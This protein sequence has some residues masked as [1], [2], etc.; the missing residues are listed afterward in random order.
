M[1]SVPRFIRPA[2]LMVD[3]VLSRASKGVSPLGRRSRNS[4]TVMTI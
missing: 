2:V 3:M 4:T 1:A